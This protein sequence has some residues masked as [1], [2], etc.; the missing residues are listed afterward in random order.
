[1]DVYIRPGQKIAQTMQSE[2]IPLSAELT[3]SSDRDEFR[4][5]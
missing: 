1:M 4:A 2:V 3:I 5:G